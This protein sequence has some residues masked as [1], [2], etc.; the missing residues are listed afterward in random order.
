MRPSRRRLCTLEAFRPLNEF[1]IIGFTLPC[2]PNYTS[3]LTV[4][5]LG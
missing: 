4:F 3:A 5:G 1:D 2:E